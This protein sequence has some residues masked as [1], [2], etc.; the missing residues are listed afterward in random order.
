MKNRVQVKIMDST[1][2]ILAD[3][4]EEYVEK[5]AKEVDKRIRDLLETNDKMSVTMAAV[6]T[7]FNLCDEARKANESA[8]N[9][10]SQIKGYL[11]EINKY[12]NQAEEARR[13]AARQQSELL[14]L[15]LQHSRDN[16]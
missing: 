9:L 14:N 7:A 8:D 11:E 3:E 6:L 12:R 4:P 2:T 1:Y 13:E 10:R 5:I 15:R 16:D